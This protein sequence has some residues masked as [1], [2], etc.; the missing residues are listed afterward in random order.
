[1]KKMREERP[2]NPQQSHLGVESNA[3]G[4]LDVATT[5]DEVGMT[6]A[7]RMMSAWVF[8]IFSAGFDGSTGF[9]KLVMR[10]VSFFGAGRTEASSKFSRTA[11]SVALESGSDA[12][13]FG[14]GFND[15]DAL[16]ED[17][18]TGG[19]GNGITGDSAAGWTPTGVAV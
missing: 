2:S 9:G 8:V 15:G 11:T 12:A 5:M 16:E 6:T 18:W 19:R 4:A 3:S 10:A 13:G 7:G 1:M 17:G 14:R